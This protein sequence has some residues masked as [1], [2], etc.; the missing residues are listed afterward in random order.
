MSGPEP[1][2]LPP[3]L[4]A[5][6]AVP[7]PAAG[8]PLR[9]LPALRVAADP[10]ALDAAAADTTW[11][12][13]ATMARIAPDDAVVL[14]DTSSGA[15]ASPGS[16]A[17]ADPGSAAGADPGSATSADPGFAAGPGSAAPASAGG[18]GSAVDPADP[19][20]ADTEVAAVAALVT[21][22]DPFAIVEP[23][24]GLVGVTLGTADAERWV[25]A[26]ADWLL[27]PGP[28]LAQGLVA[29]VPVKIL[30]RGER[31]VVLVPTAFAGELADRWEDD[32]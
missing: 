16:P 31:A 4:P 30:V 2:L 26:H 17:S 27:H 20:G 29:G 24:T 7:G 6:T 22:L 10:A 23:E 15:A 28:G 11:P 9:F 5:A 8:P 1:G 12:P 21:G 3:A 14:F 13:R 18:P 25:A 32:Q 19:P